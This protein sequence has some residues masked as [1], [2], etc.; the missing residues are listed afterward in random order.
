M[1][2][3]ILW[4]VIVAWLAQPLP[5]GEVDSMLVK[6]DQGLNPASGATL[7]KRA[8]PRANA[9]E[10]KPGGSIFVLAAWAVGSFCKSPNWAVGWGQ[11]VH[12]GLHR[13]S[14]HSS[15]SDVPSK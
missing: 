3:R 8:G 5:D 6:N 15:I 4:M 11:Q 12:D 7:I 2:S 9:F 1:T 13:G 10:S 14:S